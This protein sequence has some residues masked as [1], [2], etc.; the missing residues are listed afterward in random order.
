MS[1]IDVFG[2][3]HPGKV[4]ET[5]ADHF[6][7]ASFHRALRVH[8]TSLA[9]GIG[10]Q[11]TESRG[12]LL[13]VADGVG[14]LSS[15][16]EGSERAVATV[17]QHLLHATELCS[18]IAVAQQDEAVEDL[19]AA[20]LRAHQALLEAFKDLPRP[21]LAAAAAWSLVH[22]LSHLLLDGQFAHRDREAF[23]RDVLGAVRFAQRAG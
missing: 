3:T 17:A 2:L 18:Q 12:F 10:V 21:G 23:V 11:E 5:N 7:I 14:G 4:R 6:L 15:A 8:A 9:G 22:G 19:R 13:L 16:A 20:V 1:E